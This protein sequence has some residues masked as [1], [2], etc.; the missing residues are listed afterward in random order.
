MHKF[1]IVTPTYN[2]KQYIETT[3]KSVITNKSDNYEV[4]YIVVDGN[5]NDGTQDVVN[6]YI[7]HV[8]KFI[9]EI[10]YGNRD[11]NDLLDCFYKSIIEC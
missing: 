8:D 10:V 11:Y 6:E 7:E 2:H 4:E 9:S 5:S 3:I 1:S